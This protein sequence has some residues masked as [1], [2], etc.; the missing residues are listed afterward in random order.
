MLCKRDTA[1]DPTEGRSLVI[2]RA[3]V[4][5]RR[6]GWG[7]TV[8]GKQQEPGLESKDYPEGRMPTPGI[9]F[10]FSIK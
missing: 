6:V 3:Q 2:T 7:H 5:D 4:R 10:P 1:K 9:F 8:L